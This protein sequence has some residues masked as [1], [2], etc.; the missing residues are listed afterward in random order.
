MLYTIGSI[1]NASISFILLPLFINSL[2]VEEYGRYSL[3]IILNSVFSAIFY[4]GITSALTRSY[5]DYDSDEERNNCFYTSLV[6]LMF[7]GFLQV[8]IGTIV[9]QFLSNAVFYTN[10]YWI[11]ITLAF[12]SGAFSFINLS[13]LTLY[14]ISN[15]PGRFFLCSII[16]MI[17]NLILVYVF[18]SFFNL[19]IKG[20]ILGFLFPQFIMFCYHMFYNRVRIKK[21]VLI[22][23]EIR[24]QL[25]FGIQ[26]VISS[27]FSLA[28]LWSDQFFVNKYMSTYEVGVYSLSIKLASAITIGFVTPFNQVFNPLALEQYRKGN[29]TKIISFSY[30]YFV[31]LGFLLVILYSMTLEEL[32]YYFDFDG[33][34]TESALY[35]FP[36]MFSLLIFGLI[37]VV[38]LGFSFKRKMSDVSIIYFFS[39]VVNTLL[40]LLLI[41]QYGIK[42]AVAST[43][44]SYTI[45][46]IT[47]KIRSNE[48]F[49]V[50]LPSKYMVMSLFL[51]IFY[52]YV[53]FIFSTFSIFRR[54][55]LKIIILTLILGYFYLLYCRF[56]KSAPEI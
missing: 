39:F 51:A 30:K 3:I 20:V 47:L 37:N 34:Y 36:I 25:S 18:L 23:K 33:K 27:L 5:Y 48:F 8:T 54:I 29:A 32:L 13:F 55:S 56:K 46:M 31:T 14:R 49:N 1:L 50:R 40:N 15:L 4:F 28:I 19:G 35:V 9:S 6:L 2:E 52:Y 26:I 12:I 24:I 42:G 44:F 53:M 11:D 43:F 10:I 16:T 45:L 38:A 7:G 22:R 17:L 41:P 21:S